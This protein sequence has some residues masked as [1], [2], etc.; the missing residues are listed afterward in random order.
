MAVQKQKT[1]GLGSPENRLCGNLVVELRP[2]NSPLTISTDSCPKPVNNRYGN[3]T[4]IA[5][6]QLLS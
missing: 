5:K 3:G 4:I 6:H 1:N 2:K